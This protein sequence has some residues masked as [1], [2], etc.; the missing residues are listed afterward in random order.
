MIGTRR[1]KRWWGR[2]GIHGSGDVRGTVASLNHETARRKLK[3]TPEPW[4][5]QQWCISQMNGEFVADVEEALDLDSE[6]YDP[7]LPVVCFDETSTQLLAPISDQSAKTLAGPT[8]TTQV[9][10]LRISRCWRPQPLS[11]PRTPGRP[12][13]AILDKSGTNQAITAYATRRNAAGVGINWRFGT[14]AARIRFHRLYRRF[15]QRCLSASVAE[16]KAPAK[17]QTPRIRC[18]RFSIHTDAPAP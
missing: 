1:V 2:C 3:N 18:Q 13:H 16:A 7:S 14:D 17:R 5:K 12:A 9:G 11:V 4:R 6:P 10:R 15:F 8:G